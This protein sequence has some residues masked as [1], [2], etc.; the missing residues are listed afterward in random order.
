LQA[1]WIHGF[2]GGSV[3][4]IGMLLRFFIFGFF[5]LPG[6][7]WG[8]KFAILKSGFRLTVERW[9][10]NGGQTRLFRDGGEVTLP[11]TEVVEF[12]EEEDAPVSSNPVPAVILKP[13]TAVEKVRD[14]KAVIAE[15]A[16][17]YGLPENFVASV[18]RAESAYQPKALSPKGAIGVMQLMPGTAK[19]LGVNPHDVRQNIEGGTKLL[20]DLLLQYQDHPDQVRRALAA[21]N[22]GAGAVKKYG[23]IPP[24]TETLNYVEKVLKRGSSGY[25]YKT[26]SQEYRTGRDGSPT[27]GAPVPGRIRRFKDGAD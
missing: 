5:L 23:G 9:E 21:Y 18:A 26:D 8:A 1:D 3:Y 7:A 14:P 10:V 20:R 27:T 12:V 16:A 15:M 24:Y 13:E 17:T 2:R 11:S 6:F 22:A 4:L 25:G 19:E